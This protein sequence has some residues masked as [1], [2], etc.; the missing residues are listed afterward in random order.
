MHCC[1]MTSSTR[2]PSSPVGLKGNRLQIRLGDPYSAA[3]S[4]NRRAITLQNRRNLASPS[5]IFASILQVRQ[6]ASGLKAIAAYAM[7]AFST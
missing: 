1:R 7:D 4:G 5:Q 6:A 2:E 3:F